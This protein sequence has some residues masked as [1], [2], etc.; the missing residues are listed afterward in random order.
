MQIKKSDLDFLQLFTLG[1]DT[2]T[3]HGEYLKIR[4]EKGKATFFQNNTTGTL[5]NEIDISDPTETFQLVYPTIKLYQII[6]RI[7]TSDD[8]LIEITKK[9]IIAPDG[10]VFNFSSITKQYP[11]VT[12]L[13]EK[14]SIITQK[15]SIK[16][17]S[18]IL[19]LRPFMG[20]ALGAKN[21]MEA[22]SISSGSIFST[23]RVVASVVDSVNNHKVD[24]GKFPLLLFDKLGFEEI[25]IFY[26]TS[27]EQS[28]GINFWWFQIDTLQVIIPITK[29]TVPNLTDPA[30]A[31]L[32]E[33]PEVI[34][35]DKK[36]FQQSINRMLILTEQNAMFRVFMTVDSVKETFTIEA[37]DNHKGV[38][39]IPTKKISGK[40]LDQEGE[41]L[42]LEFLL[43]P[44]TIGKILDVL[45]GKDIHIAIHSDP[46][47]FKMVKLSDEV[48]D[49]VFLHLLL[50]K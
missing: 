13:L 47:L 1:V 29:Y 40:F 35:L 4:V 16:D 10:G 17:I 48:Q 34:S 33:N 44:Q 49:K 45:T 9:G 19:E 11:P 31:K 5:V 24:F 46:K 18:K 22:V 39:V 32:Y 14:A 3:S 25:D 12:H 2:K 30:F 8:D 15:I 26:P 7:A 21:N 36:L 37:R 23:D 50:Q 20:H 42:V 38:Q 43:N 27:T 41:P 6:N 28:Q